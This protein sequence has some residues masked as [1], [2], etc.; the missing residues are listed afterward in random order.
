V[1]ISATEKYQYALEVAAAAA[2]AAECTRL[3]GEGLTFPA[4]SESAM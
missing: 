3:V 2:A 1:G 4:I